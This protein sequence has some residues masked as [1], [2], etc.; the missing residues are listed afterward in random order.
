MRV[1]APSG[2]FLGRIAVKGGVANLCFGGDDG[3]TLLMLNET[4]AF[5]VRMKV[6]GAL[7]VTQSL[8]RVQSKE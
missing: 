2:H 6:R 1:Y 3:R 7:E 8:K 4:K 5:T